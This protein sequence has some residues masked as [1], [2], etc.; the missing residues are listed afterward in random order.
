MITMTF[1]NIAE[2]ENKIWKQKM[3]LC[4]K[5]MEV[6][7][8]QKVIFVH[9]T[10]AGDDPLGIFGVMEAFGVPSVITNVF[11]ETAIKIKNRSM[12]DLGNFTED[13]I[14]SF[15]TGVDHEIDCKSFDWSSRNNH[16]GRLLA[17][18]KIEA[19]LV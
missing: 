9:G 14:A 3:A 15:M 10:F 2:F 19:T 16:I 7:K 11:K 18:P 12:D 6:N 4:G 1:D 8:V 13:Y 17:V 5:A